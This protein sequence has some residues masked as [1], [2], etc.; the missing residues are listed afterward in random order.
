MKRKSILPT[1]FHPFCSLFHSTLQQPVQAFRH[2]SHSFMMDDLL[3]FARTVQDCLTKYLE[4]I[5]EDL[6]SLK[7]IAERCNRYDGLLFHEILTSA[8]RPLANQQELNVVYSMLA[9]ISVPTYRP[10]PPGSDG[11]RE[12]N[13]MVLSLL[14]PSRTQR[15]DVIAHLRRIGFFEKDM[16]KKVIEFSEK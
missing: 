16:V 6:P 12:T 5:A 8:S 1:N 9:A 3:V 15:Q 14:D 11:V 13:G 7:R 10:S 4:D 2:I